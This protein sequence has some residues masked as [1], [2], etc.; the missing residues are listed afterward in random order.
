MQDTTNATAIRDAAHTYAAWG[1]RVIPL[2]A[3]SQDQCTCGNAD[4]DGPG[5]HPRIAEWVDKASTSARQITRWWGHWPGANVGIVTGGKSKIAVLDIDPRNG[6]DD[7]LRD[8]E[9]S[10]R[11]LPTTPMVLTGGGGLHVYFRLPAPLGSCLLGSGVEFKAEGGHQVVAP[12][13]WH[14]SGRRYE[15]EV[16]C[17]PEDVPVAPLPDWICGL[18]DDHLTNQAHSPVTLPDH[19]S[20]LPPVTLEA[21]ALPQRLTHLIRTGEDPHNPQRYASRS[22]ALFGAILSCIHA[23]CDDLTIAALVTNPDHAISAKVLG[24]RNPRSPGYWRSTL[25]WLAQELSRARRST[26]TFTAQQQQQQQQGPGQDEAEQAAA[27]ADVPPRI[28][29]SADI[30]TVVNATIQAIQA[31]PHGPHLYQRARKLVLLGREGQAPKWLQRPPE[32]PVIV[33]ADPAYLKELAAQAAQWVKFDKRRKRWDPMIPPTW[34]IDTLLGRPHWPFPVLEGIVCAPTLR[35]DG[36]LLSTPGYDVD[37]GLFLDLNGTK[38]PALPDHPTREDACRAGIELTTVFEN[39]PF[40]DKHDVSAALAAVLSIVAR[41]A[42]QGSVPLFAVGSPVRGSGKGLLVDVIS[43]IGTGRPAARWAPTREEEEERKRLVSIALE[44]DPLVLIDNVIHPLGSPALDVALT[45]G[46][47]K[48]RVLGKLQNSGAP[49]H[50]VF[51]ATGNNLQY[52]GDMARRVVPIILDPKVERPEER[53]DFTHSPLLPWVAQERPRL[54]VAALTM[55]RAYFAAGRPAQ[56]VKPLGS[57]EAWSTLIRQALI[58]TGAPNPCDGRKDLEAESNPLFEAYAQLLACWC[59]CYQ[60]KAEEERTLGTVLEDVAWNTQPTYPPTRT[61]WH[62]FAEALA[63]F[64]PCHATKGL[65]ARCIGNALKKAQT[66][67]LNH[68]PPT[69]WNTLSSKEL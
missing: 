29:L 65:S 69:A 9:Q 37:T 14:V 55:L 28:Q 11:P 47:V 67:H 57:F 8:L 60:K 52:Y 18:V 45:A 48:D 40:Q 49:L 43:I 2:H 44:G 13:S 24:K 46:V 61:A 27:P 38:Y 51:F 59:S 5:K 30:T 50:T 15:W 33:P 17:Q 32:A 63:V 23:G 53:D 66:Q 54:V 3:I 12:P 19:P 10:Y 39:F 35:P 41:Y 42:I 25:R 62:D 58:W 22:E 6:G 36:T 31:F 34:V 26:A 7:T 20:T 56:D 64:D 21:L 4:C 68:E 1:W 16:T